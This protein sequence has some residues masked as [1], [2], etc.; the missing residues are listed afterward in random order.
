MAFFQTFPELK[1]EQGPE[2]FVPTLYG[3]KIFGQKGS[4]Y[5]AEYDEFGKIKNEEK[6]NKVINDKRTDAY[7]LYSEELNSQ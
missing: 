7:D 4:K 3:F 6:I 1:V 2:V 5:E